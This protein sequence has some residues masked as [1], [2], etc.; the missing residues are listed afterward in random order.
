MVGNNFC[1]P[2][3]QSQN[4]EWVGTPI[5]WSV[6]F[7]HFWTF[8]LQYWGVVQEHNLLRIISKLH[9]QNKAIH[10]LNPQSTAKYTGSTH[11]ITKMHH[12]YINRPHHV[13]ELQPHDVHNS[14]T[15]SACLQRISWH[16]ADCCSVWVY[17]RSADTV[18]LYQ[19][20]KNWAQPIFNHSSPSPHLS[21]LDRH[22]WL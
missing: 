15:W 3:I 21:W 5:Q 4:T 8:N 16:S 10:L 14:G 19:G 2:C 9:P 7:Y 11:H 18:P 6:H 13:P 12:H 17:C 22:D 1:I 20:M